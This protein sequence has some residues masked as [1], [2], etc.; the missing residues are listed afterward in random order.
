MSFDIGDQVYIDV[1]VDWY[2]FQDYKG[3]QGVVIGI[4]GD[5]VWV[6]PDSEELQ[7]IRAFSSIAMLSKV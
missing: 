5:Q 1:P 3:Q 2:Y 7:P 6:K 4:D